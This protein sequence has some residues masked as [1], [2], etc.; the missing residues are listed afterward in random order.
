MSLANPDG[1]PVAGSLNRER[2]A[3]T[4]TEPLGYGA[5]YTWTGSVVGRDG[6]AVP[7]AATFATI[8]PTRQVNG[9]FQL[10]DGQTVGVA[11]PIILQFDAAIDDATADVERALTVITDPPTEGSWAWLPDEVGG[12]PGALAQPGVLR[13]RHQGAR[14]R[15]AV[16]RGVRRRRLRRRRLDAG[17]RRSAAGRW[18]RPTLP[19]TASR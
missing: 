9:Q 13:A 19:R 4:V 18:S 14:R 6:K 3:F 16:R 11:A 12:C 7:V 15:P 2:T 1:K 10:S 8:N 17:L 5:A